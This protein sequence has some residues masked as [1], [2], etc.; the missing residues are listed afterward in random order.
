MV[1]VILALQGKKLTE[2][3]ADALAVAI[4]HANSRAYRSRAQLRE[5]K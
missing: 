4:C 3:E 5:A 1:Q 2:D